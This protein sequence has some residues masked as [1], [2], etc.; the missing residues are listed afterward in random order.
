[1][2]YQELYAGSPV[3]PLAAALEARLTPGS[4]GL[5]VAPAGVGKSAMLVHFALERL[6]LGEGVLHVSL[7]D[8]IDHTRA[9]YDEVFR[10]LA[11]Q[12]RQLLD[13]RETAEA[14][15]GAER[16]RMIHGFAGREFDPDQ[17]RRHLDLL[18]EAAQFRPTRLVFDGFRDG[19][20]DGGPELSRHLTAI[21]ELARSVGAVAWVAV[22]ADRPL[23]PELTQRC[24]A[25]VRLRPDASTVRV[26]LDGEGLEFHADPSS[27]LVVGERAAA[28]PAA[29]LRPESCTLYTGGAKGAEA[30]FGEAAAR[31]GLTEVAFTF[32]GH[33]QDRE[34][35]RYLLSPAELAAGDV[36]LQ[37]VSKRLNRTYNDQ[38]GLIRGVLQTLWHM[39][40]RSQQV[41]VIGAIQ[42]DGTVKGGTGWSVELART[43][44][45]DLWVYDQDR[46]GWYHWD[47]HQWQAETPVIRAVHVTGTG[48]RYMN[49]DAQ[50]AID[51]LFARSFSGAR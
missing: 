21:A 22:R 12:R 9:H 1:V 31:Y 16:H 15:V 30:A 38:G 18:A 47:G 27:M 4:V 51:D 11:S 45:R 10:A 14:Q 39:V 34:V 20:D 35:G 2:P 5:V 43:W 36:S 42:A 3:S 29:A 37:Y 6:L 19:D 50:A 28:T 49:A 44:S 33:L 17:V 26:S 24:A 23:A 40:S 13:G 46:V 8:T 32:D 48:T 41:F 25:V 7:R